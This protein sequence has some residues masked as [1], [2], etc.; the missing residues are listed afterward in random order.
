MTWSAIP[1]MG[2]RCIQNKQLILEMGEVLIAVANRP[3]LYNSPVHTLK[4]VFIY[5]S[6][7]NI[8]CMRTCCQDTRSLFFHV[9]LGTK[10]SR[11]F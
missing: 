9:H 10:T 3:T 8:V 11:D 7:N 1:E 6:C 2:T 4:S 5:L